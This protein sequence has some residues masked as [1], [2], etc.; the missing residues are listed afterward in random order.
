M[1]KIVLGLAAAG[2]MAA[3]AASAQTAPSLLKGEYKSTGQVA[4]NNGNANCAAVGLSPGASNI[5]RIVYPGAGVIGFLLYV[6]AAGGLQLCNRF[7]ATPTTGLNGWAVN[8]LCGVSGL[9]GSIPAQKVNFSFTSTATDA[10]SAYGTTTVSIPTTNTV[11]GGCQATI[12]VSLVASG[13]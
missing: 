4:S 7:P 6:P 3:S 5:S 9:A 8:G 2:L 1:N 10:N 13:H 12:Y 11:G